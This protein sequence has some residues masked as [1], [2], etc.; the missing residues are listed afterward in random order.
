MAPSPPG[1]E[2]DPI[3]ESTINVNFLSL[4]GKAKHGSEIRAD[5]NSKN[6]FCASSGRGPP[7]QGV[8]SLMSHI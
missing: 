2:A 4:L 6:A 3:A 7:F 8:L 1:A 5:F